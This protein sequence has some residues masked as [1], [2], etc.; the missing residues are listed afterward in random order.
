MDIHCQSSLLNIGAES[1]FYLY[2]EFNG[3][4][5]GLFAKKREE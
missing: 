3:D 1:Y 5:L 4:D 2:L